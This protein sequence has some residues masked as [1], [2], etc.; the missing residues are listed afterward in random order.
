MCGILGWI[1]PNAANNL[2]RFSSA[3][4]IL[5]HRGPDGVGIWNDSSISL[6]HRRLSIIDLSQTG[7]QPMIDPKSGSVIIKSLF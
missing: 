7:H 6:G 5:S 3:L 4:N 2:K 1:D